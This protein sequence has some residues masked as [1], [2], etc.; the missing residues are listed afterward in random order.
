M[1]DGILTVCG[2]ISAYVVAYQCVVAYQQDLAKAR[3]TIE[4]VGATNDQSKTGSSS[5]T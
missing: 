1:R 5:T 3:Y 4:V 2:G